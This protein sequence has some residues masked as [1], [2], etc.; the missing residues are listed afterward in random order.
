MP[1]LPISQLP[2]ST[3]LQGDELFVN[4]QGGVTKYTTLNDVFSYNTHHISCYSSASQALTASGSAQPATFTSVWTNDGI[5]VQEGSKITFANAGVYKLTFIAQLG[6]IDNAVH[7]SYFWVKYNGN[8]F[9]FSGRRMTLQPRKNSSTP[10]GQLMTVA[11]V[12]V[13][14]NDGDYIELY[15]TGD[16]P[17][18]SLQY[19][20]AA[21]GVPAIPS[22]IASVI[23]VG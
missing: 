19:T 23:R 12:G 22:I 5:T 9:P 2:Q 3:T 8:D 11:I 21:G 1:N 4:V 18:N 20:P 7:D 15:W 16:S 14:Q 6:N 17:L 13:A 10:S